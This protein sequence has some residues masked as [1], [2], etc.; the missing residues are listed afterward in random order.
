VPLKKIPFLKLVHT[1]KWSLSN[2]VEPS[3]VKWELF[4]KSPFVKSVVTS[5]VVAVLGSF[6]LYA[7]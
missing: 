1:G 4:L 2:I 7:L 5:S 6:N 3:S